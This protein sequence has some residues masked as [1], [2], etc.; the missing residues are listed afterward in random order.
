MIKCEICG[1]LNPEGH[2]Y[3]GRCGSGLLLT[4]DPD[5]D[6]SDAGEAGLALEGERKQVTVIFA[7]I[8][9]FTALNDAAQTPAQVEQVLQIVN[10]CMTIL[11]EVVYEYDGYIDKFM[12]DGIM[13]LFGAPVTHEND[14]ERAL[15][16]V[17]GMIRA[18]EAFNHHPPFPLAEPLGIHMGINTGTVIA[19]IVGTTR[20]RSYTVMGDAVNVAARLESVSERG[21]ILVSQETYNL[22]KRHFI[23]KERE[24][25]QVKGKRE[26]LVVY[27]LVGERT[28]RVG[29]EFSTALVGRQRELQQLQQVVRQLHQG[30]GGIVT[31]VGDA[32]LGKSRLVGE[33]KQWVFDHFDSLN[34]FE[35]RGLSY[36]QN[37]S[38]RLFVEILRQ[39]LEAS[40][41]QPTDVLWHTWQACGETLFAD[42][43]ADIVPY[44]ALMMGIKLPETVAQN[45]PLSEPMVLQQRMFHAFREWVKALTVEHPLVLV[46]E[47]LHWADSNSVHLIDYLMGIARHQ[48]LLLLCLTRPEQECDFWQIKP[49]VETEH[50]AYFSLLTLDPL[51][52]DQSRALMTQLLGNGQLPPNLD[53]PI[54]KRTEGNPLFLEEVVRSLVEDGTLTRLRENWTLGE[55][56]NPTDLEQK[57]PNTLTGVLTARIDRLGDS[58]KRHVQIAA[59]IGRTFQRSVLEAISEEPDKLP[60]HLTVLLGTDLI[61]KRSNGDEEV[62]AFKHALTHETAYN[63]LLLQQRRSYHRRIADYMAPW[64]YMRGE[65]YA[66]IV[67]HH[68]VQ[69]EAWDRALKYLIRAA[70]AS[71]STFDNDNAVHFYSRALD[72]AALQ[73]DRGAMATIRAGR[74]RIL[75]RLGQIDR[76]QADF[77]ALLDLA[78]SSNNPQQHLQ[79]L[80]ELG[81]LR[82][83][84]PHFSQAAQ[85]FEKALEIARQLDDVPSLVDTLIEL[86]EFKFN[87]G[88]LVDAEALYQEGL[89]LAQ[90]LGRTQ[91]IAKNEDGLVSIAISRGELEPSVAQLEKLVNAWRDIGDHQGLLKTYIYLAKT[92]TYQARYTESE[93]ICRAARK[94]YEQIGDQNW[95]PSLKLAFARNTLAQSA[96]DQ[97]LDYLNEAIAIAQKLNNGIW[98]S[99]ALSEL[100]HVLSILGDHTQ[101]QA[102]I[103]TAIELAEQAGSP[104]WLSRARLQ[105]SEI[106][107]L[108]DAYADMA[109]PLEASLQAVQQM[110]FVPES[111]LAQ[112]QR[113]TLYLVTERWDDAAAVL[114]EFQTGVEQ[115]RM[116]ALQPQVHHARARIALAQGDSNTAWR[117][118]QQG[119]QL[120]NQHGDLLT[121]L[122]MGLHLLDLHCQHDAIDE[123]ER[124]LDDVQQQF[125]QIVAQI[126]TSPQ[127]ASF[128]Q[129]RIAQHLQE[130]RVSLTS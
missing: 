36:R 99:A 26:P 90:G 38:Y 130:T 23:F 15:R 98:Q 67:A 19:G 93:T 121:A 56:V 43:T 73:Q 12:G 112:A 116:Q 84:S 37:V 97:T 125:D 30:Q 70:E 127:K 76:A 28:Q 69:G 89:H 108:S 6:S 111:L 27:E 105:Q 118:W 119:R 14:P 18:L 100:G 16:A 78:Q 92:L 122:Q 88:Q 113:L 94:I 53:T 46:F 117:Q 24:P 35:G 22:T 124:L 2:F 32:G 21:E 63:N 57:I 55:P 45:L 48:P 8:S 129:T 120:A 61:Q 41:D 83:G 39:Y 9:G 74:G 114:P 81:K 50:H 85:Y 51:G 109:A 107:L 3:C 1:F 104:L 11:G 13:A 5:S 71:R 64:Y 115:T 62:Y 44:L 40:P 75:K 128:S 123:A 91:R 102:H 42:R 126:P 60:D 7:D 101:A 68:Y 77:S 33:L 80:V 47:D 96:F 34:W 95:L 65:E 110:G 25:V 17:F 59:V 58:V 49:R 82:A 87:M 52:V 103:D 29:T 66:G 20:R 54:L 72:I 10:R 86:G 31:I 4:L 106:Y 79:A